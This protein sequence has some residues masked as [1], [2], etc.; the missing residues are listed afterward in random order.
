MSYQR[1]GPK[2]TPGVRQ[3]REDMA[4]ATLRVARALSDKFGEP[5]QDAMQIAAGQAIDVGIPVTEIEDI[6]GYTPERIDE[7]RNGRWRWRVTPAS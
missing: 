4:R 6:T 3:I 5:A 1:L 7:I 2:E